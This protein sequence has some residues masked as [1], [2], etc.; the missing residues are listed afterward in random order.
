[1]P[2]NAYYAIALS[3]SQAVSLA[4]AFLAWRRRSAPGSIYLALMMLAVA[5]WS[6]ASAIEIVS[7]DQD[8]KIVWL[9]ISFIG[10]CAASPLFLLFALYYWR[11]ELRIKLPYQICIWLIPIATI[12]LST[13]NNTHH[14]MWSSFAI[15]STGTNILTY[16]HGVWFWI[17]VAYS[18]IVMLASLIVLSRVA[19]SFP[20]LYRRQAFAVLFAAIMPWVGNALYVFGG[21]PVSALVAPIVFSI[22]GLI[23]AMGI[24]KLRLFDIVPVARESMIQHVD[25][26]MLVMDNKARIVD[27]NPAA[28]RIVGSNIEVGQGIE[29]ALAGWPEM[30]PLSAG[31]NGRKEV[32]LEQRDPPLWLDVCISQLHDR[33]DRA[34]GCLVTLQDITERKRAELALI[35]ARDALEH[36]ATH[37]P[38]T[39]TL[40][41]RAILDVLSRE[42]SRARRQHIGLAIGI[43]DIDHFKKINDTYG[44]PVGDEVLCGV[45]RIMNGNLRKYDTLGRFG[46]EEFLVITPGVKEND[47]ITV[48]KRLLSEVAENPLATKSGNV[49]VTMS[50]GVKVLSGEEEMEELLKAADDA[51]YDAKNGGRNRVFFMHDRPPV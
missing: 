9:Q 46:G 50:I 15:E 40:N 24:L 13:T 32:S 7:A 19:I 14:L 39:G 37:D 2:T 28:L 45:V 49:S 6:A 42:L 25:I 48:Y 5:L 16:G 44:H 41:R 20:W 26:G 27:F 47:A 12:I 23:F 51:L 10:V 43:C 33:S 34:S 22:A 18:Y 30:P 4:V 3:V 29:E 36:Q 8:I 35:E 11:P 21:F 38:L 1:M 17:S 31:V